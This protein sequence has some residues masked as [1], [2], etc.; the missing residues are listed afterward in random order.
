MYYDDASQGSVTLGGNGGGGGTPGNGTGTG[1]GIRNLADG[2]DDMDAVNVR[3]LD[4]GDAETL[5][6]ANTYTDT[7]ETV[8]R[9]DM[10]AGDTATL[11]AANTYT[12][13]TASV[14]LA[15]AKAYTDVRFDAL[16]D[17]FDLF[18][19]DVNQRFR[20]TDR[21]IDQLGAMTSAM[22]NMAINAGGSQSPRG[23]IA[24]GAGVQGGEQALSIGYG[25][26]IGNRGSFSIGGAFGGGEKSA[27][28][29][30]GV[31]L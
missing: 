15:S 19:G 21:R 11:Q 20:Q 26:R 24:V 14:T 1:T 30:F 9:G 13:N 16:D 5:A 29:G 18:R 31:D 12:D 7:R 27:G 6:S 4:A 17:E 22:T 25:R 10:A 8:I 3:Q 23:R 2:V 28:L